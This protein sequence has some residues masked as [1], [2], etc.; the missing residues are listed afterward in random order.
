MQ[1]LTRKQAVLHSFSTDTTVLSLRSRWGATFVRASKQ[2]ALSSPLLSI[3]GVSALIR[4][5]SSCV[6]SASMDAEPSGGGRAR[7]ERASARGDR[8]PCPFTISTITGD[9]SHVSSCPYYC[10]PCTSPANMSGSN[11]AQV[12]SGRAPTH[13]RM[14]RDNGPGPAHWRPGACVR[15][16]VLSIPDQP[17]SPWIFFRASRS[18]PPPSEK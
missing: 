1:C 8:Q 13:D 17:A 9:T 14:R 3:Y 7:D 5:T 15:R 6:Q 16:E 18:A 12:C 2:S 4:L 10:R 11:H